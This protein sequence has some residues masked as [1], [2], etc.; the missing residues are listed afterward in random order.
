MW[1]IL[2]LLHSVSF[3]FLCAWMRLNALNFYAPECAWMRSV[4]NAACCIHHHSQIVHL[5]YISSHFLRR[6]HNHTSLHSGQDAFTYILHTTHSV[7]KTHT[8]MRRIP[9]SW[10]RVYAFECVCMLSHLTSIYVWMCVYAYVCMCMH[11]LHTYA[12]VC[13]CFHI[14]A[15]V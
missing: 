15:Y 10:I 8:Q 1:C 14:Y 13:I 9:R 6:I 7:N 11:V 4:L 2:Y 12:Y 3:I 5:T